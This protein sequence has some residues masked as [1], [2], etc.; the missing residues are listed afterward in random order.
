LNLR[1]IENVRWERV[2]AGSGDSEGDRWLPMLSRSNNNY[3]RILRVQMPDMERLLM[4]SYRPRSRRDVLKIRLHY[5]S[6]QDAV[7]VNVEGTSA[8]I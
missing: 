3:C 7:A 2:L 6:L 4:P 5:L 8:P 1:P